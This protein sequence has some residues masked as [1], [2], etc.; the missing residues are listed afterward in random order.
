MLRRSNGGVDVVKALID[1]IT[2]SDRVIVSLTQRVASK[3]GGLQANDPWSHSNCTEGRQYA[4]QE[5]QGRY[6]DDSFDLLEK[7]GVVCRYTA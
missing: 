4:E 6:H 3:S 7:G 2:Q 5:E 1:C